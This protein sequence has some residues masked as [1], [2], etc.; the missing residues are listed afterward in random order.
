MSWEVLQGDCIERMAEM[1][2]ASVDAVVCD[3]PY[4]LTAKR[5]GGRSPA[6]EGKVMRGFMGLEWDGSGIAFQAETWA[7]ALRVLKPGGHLLAFGGTRTCH[8]L[9]TAIESAGFEIR[10]RI[11][12]LVAADEAVRRFVESL[13]SAQQQAFVSCLED[14]SAEIGG[15]LLYLFGTGFP[16]SH[17]LHGEW[18]GFGT[19]LKPAFEPI[20]VARKPFKGTVAEC[21][22]QHGT[23]GINIDGCRIESGTDY[24]DLEVTQGGNHRHDVGLTEKT[25]HAE[26]VPAAGRWPANAVFSEEAAAELDAQTGELVSGPESDKGHRRNA[27]REAARNAYGG[28]QGQEA[29]GVLYGDRGGASRFFYCAKTSR[30]ERNAGLEG[31]EAQ[32]KQQRYGDNFERGRNPETG[33]RTERMGRTTLNT[34]PTVKPINLM[35]WLVRLVTPPGGTCLD[36]FLGSGSTGCAAVLEGF[37]FIG[38]ERETEYIAIAEARV[39]FWAKHQGREV[40]DVLGLYSASQKQAKQHADLGQASLLD[41]LEAV[42]A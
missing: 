42:Q 27:D 36:P 28:F 13:S 26:F 32:E 37:D 10:D 17:N 19:A 6:T 39:A 35:R 5:P 18:E 33:E 25:R 31:F 24:H 1:E 23:G 41:N 12:T 34:H 30:A 38:I 22:L 7:K 14:A 8:R 21:V 29:T 9:T 20:V 2:E 4:D 3:P 15:T 16:K 11:A 40:E